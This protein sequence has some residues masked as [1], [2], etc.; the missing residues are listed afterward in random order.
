MLVYE[1]VLAERLPDLFQLS[2]CDYH[3]GWTGMRRCADLLQ[4]K[5]RRRTT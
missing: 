5:T 3:T 4:V 1:S 2:Y